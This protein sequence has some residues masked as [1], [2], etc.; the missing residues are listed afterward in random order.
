MTRNAEQARLIVSSANA[1][2]RASSKIFKAAHWNEIRCL[3][4]LA[5]FK[6]GLNLLIFSAG[7]ID[8]SMGGFCAG[9]HILLIQAGGGGLL[10]F[11]RKGR[12]R[13]VV[14]R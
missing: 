4:L 3:G 9:V 7:G 2:M 12:H 6:L 1:T 11:T 8:R 14:P 10:A 5:F 13:V